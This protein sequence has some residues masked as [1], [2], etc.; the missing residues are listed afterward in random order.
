MKVAWLK[1]DK[2]TKDGIKQGR[3]EKVIKKKGKERRAEETRNRGT[4]IRKVF[5]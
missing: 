2:R 3:K 4:G 1:S 5:D